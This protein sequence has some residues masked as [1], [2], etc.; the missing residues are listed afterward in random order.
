MTLIVQKIQWRSG[1]AA[2]WTTANPVLLAGEA[3]YETDT[4]KWK[5]GN[6]SSAWSALIYQG[7]SGGAVAWGDIGGTLSAQADLQTALNGKATAAQGATADTALQ[8][9][10]VGTAAYAAA[11]DFATAA[12]GA[13]ADSA[14]QPG[15]LSTVAT[16]GAYADLTGKPTLG[17]AAATNATAYAT[18]AQGATADTALQPADVGTAAAED[19]GTGPGNVVQLD[20]SSRL[21]AVDGSQLTGIPGGGD[22]SGPASSVD[23]RIA[24]FSGTSGKVLQ[25]SGAMVS[26]FAT[27]A[28]GAAA[29]SAVQ[30]G[31]LATV[32]T[33]G[34]YS[35]LSGQP[36][37]GDVSGPAVS[38]TARIATFNGTT[39]KLIQDSGSVV[40]DFATAAQGALADSA[41]QPGDLA[42]VA[43]TGAYADLSGKPTLGSAAAQNTTAFATAAQGATADTAVQPARSISTTAPLTGGGDLSA[44]RTFAIPAATASV[45]GYATAVQITKL[46]GIAIGATA[47]SADAF[48]LARA[49]HTGTQAWSTL[50]STPTTLAGYG[51]SDGITAAVAASTYETITNVALKAPLASP[52]FTGTP[53][54][55]TAAT[56]S[57]TTQ[58][59]TTAYVKAQLNSTAL[60]GTPTAPTAAFGTNTT[61]I[62]TTAHVKAAVSQISVQSKSAAYTAVLAD[63]GTCLFHPAADTTAR[64]FTIPANASVAYPVGTVLTIINQN[65]AGVIT[66]AITTD[67]M[68]LAGAGTTGS[69]TLAANGIA[70]ATKITST[71]WI[72]SGT[73]L[74]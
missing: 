40:G 34:A 20:G 56:A 16:T 61:Q 12:Q 22:V 24:T 43:T 45:D 25:D 44:N 53:A 11:G 9:G 67:T 15:D 7:G 68:R 51:I 50:T 14:T 13:L 59:A 32:A 64:T 35:D 74:T 38:V 30:P 66:I 58:I 4:G 18:A 29:D 42:T 72:I 36:T 57:N 54:A 17:T 73:G 3:G 8:P 39:G 60:T 6:G 63:A 19:V 46:D 37:F 28:Q 5:L 21:P 48:L 1:T 26:D 52:T 55:P 49:N 23:T 62:A 70:T 71:E 2:E 65:G 47:N 69:R 27:A 10:D 33:T 31:D 41:T